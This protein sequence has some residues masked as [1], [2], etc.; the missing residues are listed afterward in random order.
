MRRA[1]SDIIRSMASRHLFTLMRE[2]RAQSR[3]APAAVSMLERRRE[4]R[5]SISRARGRSERR[6]FV[7]RLTF[8]MGGLRRFLYY[9]RLLPSGQA[10]RAFRLPSKCRCRRAP[11]SI[12]PALP[13]IRM[14]VISHE[15]LSAI[16]RVPG[17]WP[18]HASYAPSPISCGDTSSNARVADQAARRVDDELLRRIVSRATD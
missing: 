11:I 1:V 9:F 4:P 15:A 6:R 13:T 10:G 5:S 17:H 2:R 12:L 16:S 3:W 8:E 7:F 14:E 18:R